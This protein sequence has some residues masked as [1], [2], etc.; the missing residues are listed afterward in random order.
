M[1]SGQAA[2]GVDGPDGLDDPVGQPATHPRR[3]AFDRRLAFCGGPQVLGAAVLDLQT[4]EAQPVRQD[5]ACQFTGCSRCHAA[6]TLSASTISLLMWM[7][8]TPRSANASASL[9]Y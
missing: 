6:S 3:G 8:G 5:V 7:S 9:S 4:G 1:A 2:A